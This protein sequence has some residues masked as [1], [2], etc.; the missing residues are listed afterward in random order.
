MSAADLFAGFDAMAV[1][2]VS[3]TDRPLPQPA[4]KTPKEWSDGLDVL[5][6]L[7]IP[8]WMTKYQWGRLVADAQSFGRLWA[9]QAHALGWT[10]Q[11]LFGCPVNVARSIYLP[12]GVVYLLEGRNVLEIHADSAVIENRG[13]RPHVYRRGVGDRTSCVAIWE[14]FGGKPA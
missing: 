13:T 10:V 12:C 6:Q 8:D 7:P 9:P 5:S 11:E 14:A 4:L 2:G 1:A 3:V